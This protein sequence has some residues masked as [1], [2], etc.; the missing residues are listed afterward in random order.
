MIL[1]KL[2]GINNEQV[3][4]LMETVRADDRVLQYTIE[5]L[6][7]N[8]KMRKYLLRLLFT[9]TTGDENAL[10]LKSVLIKQGKGKTSNFDALKKKL[11]TTQTVRF[12]VL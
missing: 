11:Q 8:G 12:Y 3:L 1:D 9:P 10:I 5:S 4:N 7:D 6:L 2:T